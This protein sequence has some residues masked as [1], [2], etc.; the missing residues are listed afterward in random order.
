VTVRKTEV[1]AAFIQSVVTK[2][3]DMIHDSLAQP[4]AARHVMEEVNKFF[5]TLLTIGLMRLALD[6][7]VS[8]FQPTRDL[9]NV[10][11]T[12]KLTQKQYQD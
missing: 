5:T 11:E 12:K 4:E 3:I 9:L 6:G 1:D 2:T 8:K 7:V 10:E